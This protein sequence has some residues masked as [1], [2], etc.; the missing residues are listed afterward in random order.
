M[1][2][3]ASLISIFLMCSGFWNPNDVQK[4]PEASQASQASTEDGGAAGG[5]G[6]PGSAEV[7]KVVGF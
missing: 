4:K 1:P 7:S 2:V 6:E 5:A 3:K